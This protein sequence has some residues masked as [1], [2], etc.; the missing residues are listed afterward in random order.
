MKDE[1][2]SNWQRVIS[3]VKQHFDKTADM[4]AILFLIG[5]RELG[6][7]PEKNFK[8]EEK[9]G[10]MHI[11]TCKVLSYSGHYRLVGKDDEGWPHWE[12]VNKVPIMN[13]FEQEN[14]LRQHIVEYFI[15]EEII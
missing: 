6:I 4:N 9:V 8:K 5:I 10:L 15:N 12:L 7:L 14:Y 13:M 1:L 3:Y 2:V 11:A